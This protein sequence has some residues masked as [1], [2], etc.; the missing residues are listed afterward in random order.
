MPLLAVLGHHPRDQR[1]HILVHLG[2][3]LA[4]IRGFHLDDLAQQRERAV[5]GERD[6]SGERLIKSDAQRVDVGAF[7]D[8]LV[9]TLLGGEVA[10]GAHQ[11]AGGGETGGRAAH[12]SQTEV[13]DLDQSAID[14]EQVGRFDVAVD[15]ALLVGGLQS[16]GGLQHDAS[17][18]GLLDCFF[19]TQDLMQAAAR[20]VLHDEEVATFILAHRV[21]LDDVGVVEASGALRLA[22]ESLDIVGVLFQVLTEDL[23][24][25]ES[26]EGLLVS[27]VNDSHAAAAELG[28]D[29]VVAD[30]IQHLHPSYC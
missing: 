9:E 3:E 4:E 6:S 14:D 21:D 1:A 7:V 2:V 30:T 24:G 18:P 10:R 16:G 20:D 27:P 12:Q 23:D 29:A 25:D 15:D 5:G 19:R 26:V 11:H 22:Q 28:D 13:R 8:F 17:R